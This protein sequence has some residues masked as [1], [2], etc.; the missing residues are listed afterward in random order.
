MARSRSGAM[1][2]WQF[3]YPTGKMFGLKVTSYVDERCD[4]YKSTKAA[5]EYFQYLYKMFGNWE[6]GLA[7]YNC[8]PG[9]VS[10]AIRRSGGKR[11]YWE[12]RPFLPRETQGYIPAFIAVNYIMNHAD[13]HNIRTAI[14]KKRFF[15]VDTVFVKKQLSFYQIS[16]V[17][18]IKE[19]ELR[20]LNPCY[21]R[22]IIP[23]V[24]GQ[25]NTLTL[26]KDKM[27]V[28]INNEDTI[29]KHLT[30]EQF[31]AS[32]RVTVKRKA[33]E[34]YI[35]KSGDN[36]NS[37]ARKMGCSVSSLKKWNRISSNT[38]HPGKRL[39]IYNHVPKATNSNSKGSGKYLYHTIKRGDS[40][41]KIAIQYKTTIAEIRRL[42]NYGVNYTLLP[43]KRMKVGVL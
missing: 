7:A 8:G 4:P 38:I 3:M 41:Y 31:V 34:T 11:N 19:D 26:P 1:G 37:I 13:E 14:P 17:L 21:R 23:A 12:I 5:C 9:T 24:N 25:Q 42:N 36:L 10:R 33:V 35:V 18:N 28:F 43:G 16:K 32:Q 22:G 15:E 39:V 6:L 20:Y 2:L 40:F 30:K 29:Y 27:G